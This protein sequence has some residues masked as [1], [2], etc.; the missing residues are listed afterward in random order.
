MLFFEAFPTLE[1]ENELH[2]V[3]SKAEVSSVTALPDADEVIV[4]AVSNK[5]ITGLQVSGMEKALFDT[6]FSRAGRL[7]NLKVAFS[8][9]D[10]GNFETMWEKY[11][12]YMAEEIG[13]KSGLLAT[14]Y[15]NSRVTAKDRVITV[16][17]EENYIVREK[18]SILAATIID[19]WK[20]RF[21]IEVKVEFKY[22]EPEKIDRSRRDEVVRVIRKEDK[23]ADNIP[24]LASLDDWDNDILPDEEE[25]GISVTPSANGTPEAIISANERDN[26][27]FVPTGKTNIEDKAGNDTSKAEIVNEVKAAPEASAKNDRSGKE[28]KASKAS[29]S[30]GTNSKGNRS[31]WKNEKFADD[32]DIFYGR[33]IEGDPVTIAE[34]AETNGLIVVRGMV[35][36]CE[37]RLTKTGKVLVSFA[38]TDFTDSILGKIFLAPE[39][40]DAVLPK[41]QKGKF[42]MLKGVADY[43]AYDREVTIQSVQGIKTI[44]DFRHKRHDDAEVKR[45]ELHAHTMMSDMDG[46]IPVEKLVRR[47]LEWG[48][49]G[50]AITDHGVVQAFPVAFHE[51]TRGKFSDEE[52]ERLK[53]FRIVYGCEGYIVDDEVDEVT[54]EKGRTFKRGED[55]KYSEEDIRHMPSHHIILLCKND[56]GRVNLYKL[57]S[58]AHLYYFGR[59]PRIPKSLLR[60]N[61]EG[62]IVGSACEAGELFRSIVT[63]KP[64]EEVDRIASFYDYYEI[65]QV[66]NNAYMINDPRFPDVNSVEDLK[67][68]NMRISELAIRDNKPC[69][70]TCDVHF[71]DP[72]DEVYRRILMASKGFKDAD[73]QAPLFLH[74]TDEMLSEC[75]YL[76]EKRAYE[77]VVEYPNKIFDSIEKIDPVRPDKCPPVIEDSDKTLR[78]ICENKA[79][80]MYGDVLPEAVSSRL[81]H[82]LDSIIK[83]GF[84]VMYIIAQKLVWKSNEDGYLVGSRGSVGS[85]FVATMAGISEINPLPPHYYCPECHYSEFD[86]DICKEYSNRSGFD[87]PDKVCPV[88]G[89]QLVKDGQNIPFETFLGFYGDK[90]PDIDLNF[91]GE[92]QSKAHDYTEVIFGKGQT[93]RAGT[94]GT[95]A[96]KT[97]FG[98]VSKYYEERGIQ[99]RTVEKE[100][101]ADGCVGVRRTSGQHPGGIVVLP[102]GENIFSFTPLQHP[103]NDLTSPI[104]TTHFEYHSIDHNL[105][106]LDILGHDDPTMVRMLED[107]T[108][109]DVKTIPMD[110]PKVLS[111]FASTEAIGADPKDIDGIDL[112]CLGLPELGTNFVMQMLKDA[113]PKTFSDMVKI[114]GLS[115]GTDVWTNNASDYIKNG[116]CTIE[117]AIC[118]RDDIMIYLISKG[119]EPGLAFKTMESVRKGKGLQP[120]MEQ[121]MI[122]NDV[123]QWYIDSCKKIKYMFPKAHACAYMVMAFRIAHFKV[124]HP[125]AYYAAFFSIRATGFDYEKMALGKEELLRRLALNKS[126]PKVN[127]TARD[128]KELDDMHLVLEFYAR[129]FSFVPID[130][131]R[132]KARHFIIVDGALMPSLV[133]LQGLG[134]KAAEMIEDVSSK[135]QFLS[136]ND[137]KRSC[138]VSDTIVHLMDELGILKD[139]PDSEQISFSDMFNM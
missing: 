62:I 51:L 85:S 15:R 89:K 14:I 110:D 136:K 9:E 130:I 58:Y 102:H 7:V 50:I 106:K 39:E 76:G 79:H 108:G 117:T 67:R 52:K 131:Y 105:L 45:I 31:K 138:K 19:Y 109:V 34:I 135:K 36:K 63:N 69:V 68:I 100:R 96:E 1:A 137:F 90:E 10:H 60:E 118:T 66:G 98:I 132:A 70:A 126:V 25:Y 3:F 114:S 8:F 11:R 21:D 104:I 88:C 42:I 101:L 20:E 129:G 49:R 84:A 103:A 2:N 37:D 41:I 44:K 12:L 74:T 87:L 122:D 18:Q 27:D 57:V 94:I 127:R 83:N 38:I 112:G 61:R 29:K 47:A 53:D 40:K 93:F 133:T 5:Y 30:G 120:E 107:L 116:D 71:L 134:E 86:S 6:V 121:A 113:K 17:V 99:M 75:A 65:Q 28:R 16:D 48:H 77:V 46:V 43:N 115:H 54:D 72:E 55:G 92:Y 123:P 22:H 80:S 23:Q 26:I 33:N 24:S 73:E 128:D 64:Q 82:E 139:L 124:Y 32:P 4:Y 35:M 111:L 13:A 119:L 56:I 81:E 59:H 91:S 95:L 78:E 125:L 97:A